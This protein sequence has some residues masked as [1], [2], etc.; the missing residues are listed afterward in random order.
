MGGYVCF[1][2]GL[3]AKA[4]WACRWCWSTPMRPAAEQ[5]GP[6]A[7][8]QPCGL[9]FR[10]PGRQDKVSRVTGNPV[11]AEIEAMRRRPSALPAAPGPLRVLVVGGSLGARAL[12]DPAPGAGPDPG[13]AA[14]AHHAPDRHAN[15]DAV[16]QLRA[17]R[18]TPAGVD[19]EVLPFIDD[20]AQRLADCDV[21]ICR[22]GAI[23]VS[24]LCAAGVPS[25]LVPLVVST[26][27]HQRDNAEYMAEHGAAVH[28][29]QAEMSAASLAQRLQ[30]LQRDELLAMARRPVVWPVPIGRRRGRCHRR[31]RETLYCKGVPM[32][33]AVKHIHFVGIGGAGMSG[34]AEILHNLGYVVSGSDQADSATTRRLAAGHH[35]PSATMPRTSP[36]P[37]PWSPPPP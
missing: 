30:G 6:A 17:G 21:I 24:E 15:L 35:R 26:T 11:R 7:A 9:R 23:T 3:M 32:K 33:H 12:N 4:R 1:P 34:I 20:M 18:P 8:D 25:V 10:R 16:G 14:P 2:G 22:A 5:Q 19:A 29:P 37:K 31:K 13:R 28:L 36:A 27:A